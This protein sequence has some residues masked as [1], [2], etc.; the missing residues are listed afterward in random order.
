MNHSSVYQFNMNYII[1]A[2]KG[3][4][5]FRSARLVSLAFFE[6]IRYNLPM[7]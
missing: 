7:V 1:S 5:E 6:K 2:K 3:Q 4:W